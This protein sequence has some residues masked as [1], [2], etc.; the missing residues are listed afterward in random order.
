MQASN[1]GFL[2]EMME[3]GRKVC[4]KQVRCSPSLVAEI[5]F[6]EAWFV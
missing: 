6:R 5:I 4:S 2:E 3:D 1:R